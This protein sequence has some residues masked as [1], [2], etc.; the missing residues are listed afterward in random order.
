MSAIIHLNADL[1]RFFQQHQNMDDRYILAQLRIIRVDQPKRYE[2][3]Q[4]V[5]ED[6]DRDGEEDWTERVIV[7]FRQQQTYYDQEK[8]KQAVTSRKPPMYFVVDSLDLVYG[9]PA[10]SF[11]DVIRKCTRES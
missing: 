7:A 11:N 2:E 3:W 4:A 5:H 8:N 1:R 9:M 6:K 10:N